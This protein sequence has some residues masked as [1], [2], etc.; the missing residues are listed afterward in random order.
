MDAISFDSKREYNYFKN[1]LIDGKKILLNN[2][3]R[4]D[5]LSLNFEF[6][7]LFQRT[8]HTFGH[9]VG[10][11]T[12]KDVKEKTFN[13]QSSTDGF[14]HQPIGGFRTKEDVESATGQILEGNFSIL[15]ANRDH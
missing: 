6:S 12:L 3:F 4:R 5:P 7:I 8:F 1:I 11:A 9:P 2:I 13:Q 15:L 14:G 10:N